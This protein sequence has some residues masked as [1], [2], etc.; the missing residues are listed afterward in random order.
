M[1]LFW[2]TNDN[3]RAAYKNSTPQDLPVSSLPHVIY[4]FADVKPETGEV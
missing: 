3:T 4:A 2:L 1:A